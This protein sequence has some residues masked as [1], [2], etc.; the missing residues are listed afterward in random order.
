MNNRP[1]IR[2]LLVEDDEEDFII[3][4]D[5]LSEVKGRRFMVE[6]KQNYADGL[7][8]MQGNNQD[9]CLVDYRLGAHDGLELLRTAKA[10]GAETPVILL[11]GQGHEEVDMAAMAAGAADYLV[12]GQVNAHQLERTIRYAIE[13]KR[14]SSLAAF[15][16]ARIASF[17]TQVGLELTRRAPL[18]T[19]LENCARAMTQFLNCALAQIWV[20]DAQIAEFIPC[21]HAGSVLE[22]SLTTLGFP[23]LRQ[24]KPIFIGALGQHPAFARQSWL[25]REQFVSFAAYPLILEEQPVGCISLFSKEPLAETVLQE[26]GS[27]AYGIALCIQRKQDEA[28]VQRLTN[29]SVGKS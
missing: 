16:Q 8:A 6:W 5:L 22:E 12:K 14:A 3:T 24:G 28:Q 19:Q 17:G 9:V 23:D 21:A 2:V 15:E 13:R 4:R 27:V 10:A 1:V 26:L 29:L 7:A 18:E 11:T 25:Q 20:Y